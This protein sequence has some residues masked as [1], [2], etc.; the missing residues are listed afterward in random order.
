MVLLGNESESEVGDGLKMLLI[1]EA[2]ASGHGCMRQY[3]NEQ[4]SSIT[5]SCVVLNLNCAR[6]YPN[7]SCR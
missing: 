7:E 6:D 5:L 4:T 2:K 3:Y 1:H